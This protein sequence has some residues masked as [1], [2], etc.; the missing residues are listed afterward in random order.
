MYGRSLAEPSVILPGTAEGDLTSHNRWLHVAVVF[1][2]CHQRRVPADQ[3]QSFVLTITPTSGPAGPHQGRAGP[4]H[5]RATADDVQPRLAPRPPLRP[6]WSRRKQS[7]T[8]HGSHLPTSALSSFSC[9]ERR[10]TAH[11]S[12]RNHFRPDSAGGRALD[13]SGLVAAGL[14]K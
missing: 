4:A 11:A 12:T 6:A 10:R 3:Q 8:R 9:V 5:D 2:N 13:R 7:V 1:I 14:S